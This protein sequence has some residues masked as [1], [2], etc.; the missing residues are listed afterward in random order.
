MPYKEKKIKKI[1]YKIGEIYDLTE[2]PRHRIRWFADLNSGY[3]KR[4]RAGTRKVHRDL[5]QVLTKFKI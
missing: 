1:W 5:V 2:I 3:V 4:D